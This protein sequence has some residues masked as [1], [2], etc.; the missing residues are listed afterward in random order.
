MT[1][2]IVLN[3]CTPKVVNLSPEDYIPNLALNL[4][5]NLKKKKQGVIGPA[6]KIGG[7]K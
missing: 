6:S 2:F 3:I 4:K 5:L 1:Q 7:K